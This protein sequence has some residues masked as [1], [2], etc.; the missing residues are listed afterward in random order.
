MKSSILVCTLLFA[1]FSIA[2]YVI[3]DEYNPSNFLD[4]FTAFTGLD[5]TE[6]FGKNS[7]QSRRQAQHSFLDSKLRR[8][9]LGEIVGPDKN[10]A[11]LSHT[12]RG[13]YQR[14][15]KWTT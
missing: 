4:S 13:L 8:H 3:E 7:L 12:R 15:S 14:H 9:G 6:G 11:R 10:N 2:G 1:N 5:P